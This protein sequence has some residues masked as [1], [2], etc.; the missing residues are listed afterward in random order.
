MILLFFKWNRKVIILT[1][2]APLHRNLSCWQISVL[3]V[4][5]IRQFIY[6]RHRITYALPW[7]HNEGDGVSNYLRTDGLLNG[8]SGAD[9]RNSP[10]PADS[11][12]KGPI[13]RKMFQFDDVIIWLDSGNVVIAFGG[14]AYIQNVHN[15]KERTLA[16]RDEKMY[17]QVTR[18]KFSFNIKT[19][20]SGIMILIIKMRSSYLYDKK[21]YIGKTASLCWD[22]MVL[23]KSGDN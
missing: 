1:K 9:H 5:Q 17:P 21:A 18:A 19:V 4:Q 14:L 15:Y 3:S 11:P 13:T 16:Q 6:S 10:W 23:G 20:F 8:L 2:F 12:H 22:A 7:R